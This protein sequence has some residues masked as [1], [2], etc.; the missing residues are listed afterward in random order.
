VGAIQPQAQRL[1]GP[2]FAVFSATLPGNIVSAGER[3]RIERQTRDEKVDC[4]VAV[5]VAGQSGLG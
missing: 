4:F 2:T 1:A 5:F 3:Y